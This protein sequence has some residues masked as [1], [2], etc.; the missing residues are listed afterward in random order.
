MSSRYE[1]C[2]NGL[3]GNYSVVEVFSDGRRRIHVT[4]FLKWRAKEIAAEQNGRLE[5]EGK[6]MRDEP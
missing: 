6:L 5:R 1:I 2:E 3:P 4:G